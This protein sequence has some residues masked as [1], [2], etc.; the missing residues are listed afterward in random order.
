MPNLLSVLDGI[1]VR[2]CAGDLQGGEISLCERGT[3][4]KLCEGANCNEK[5]KPI[6]PQ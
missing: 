2:G 5:G 6:P 4:C 1:V 3:Q